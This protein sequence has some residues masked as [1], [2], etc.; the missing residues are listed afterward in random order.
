MHCA[1]DCE[2]K[3]GSFT[4][5]LG[6]RL[7]GLFQRGSMLLPRFR[8]VFLRFS[9][10]VSA[11]LPLLA[12]GK[13]KVL[14]SPARFPALRGFFMLVLRAARNQLCGSVL[15]RRVCRPFWPSGVNARVGADAPGHP[16]APAHSP[17]TR[18][19]LQMSP[20]VASIVFAIGLSIGFALGYGVRAFISYR[21][22]QAA[23]RWRREPR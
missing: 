2:P 20:E 14:L 11:G 19:Q 9:A 10:I 22:R 23:R 5:S 6:V 13:S 16:K 3:A 4:R 8:H 18:L 17:A 15:S 1:T 12:F 21:R 7:H